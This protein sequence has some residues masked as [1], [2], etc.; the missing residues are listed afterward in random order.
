MDANK[1]KRF[2]AFWDLWNRL[3]RRD[4]AFLPCRQ[5]LSSAEMAPFLPR[6]G[7]AEWHGTMSLFMTF[8]GSEIEKMSGAN[9]HQCNFYDFL[10][11]N[12]RDPMKRFHNVIFNTPCGA[13]VGEVLTVDN[14][15]NYLFENIQV[16]VIGK[17]GQPDVLLIYAHART[18]IPHGPLRKQA[19]STA[20]TIRDFHYIDLGGGAPDFAMENH[21]P[22]RIVRGE[23]RP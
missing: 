4:H 20:S 1:D 9:L 10:D 22:T 2:D 14:G 15:Q 23:D 18:T 11:P 6:M 7:I 13:Y 19:S 16:P 5:D 3:P 21:K 17:S 8:F 12:L